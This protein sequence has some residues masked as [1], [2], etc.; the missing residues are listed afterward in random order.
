M[1][2]FDH[3]EHRQHI[4]F[5]CTANVDRSKTAEDLYANDPRFEVKSCGVAPF[6]Q[7]V[8]T[9]ELL[10]WADYVFVMNETEDHHVTAIRRR[11]PGLSKEIIN[12]DVEDR[13]K[14][15]HPELARL[16][17]SRLE[18]HIGKPQQAPAAKT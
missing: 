10:D 9:R 17:I 8:V 18:P 6:A 13:W 1:D 5:V 16:I 15:G 2:F 12:L 4:L 7:V 11:F 3:A 14:R